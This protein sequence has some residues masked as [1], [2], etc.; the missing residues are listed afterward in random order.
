MTDY[1][2]MALEQTRVAT[3]ACNRQSLHKT[4]QPAQAQLGQGQHRSGRVAQLVGVA[5][6]CVAEGLA[7]VRTG[8]SG[9]P[10][11]K[12]LGSWMNKFYSNFSNGQTIFRIAIYDII[13][14][15]V[16][17]FLNSIGHISERRGCY[18]INITRIASTACVP[19]FMPHIFFIIFEKFHIYFYF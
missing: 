8:V 9:K 3:V 15:I 17:N 19:K 11:L 14:N 4:A 5:V 6:G 18:C 7:K 1:V 16:P 10:Y 12:V 13:L 2:T